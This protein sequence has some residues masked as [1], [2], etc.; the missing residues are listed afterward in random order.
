MRKTQSQLA[1][2]RLELLRG[3]GCSDTDILNH[4]MGW[5]TGDQALEA[6]N[7]YATDNDIE[8]ED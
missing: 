2:E 6:I 4:F 7:D 1:Y 5:I 8:L 3:M